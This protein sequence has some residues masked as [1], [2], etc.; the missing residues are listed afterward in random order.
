MDKFTSSLQDAFSRAHTA[1]V[2][3]N[4]AALSEP[5]L[6]WALAAP[7][8][9]SGRLLAAAG[10]DCAMLTQRMEALFGQLPKLGAAAQELAPDEGLRQLLQVAGRAASER[11]DGYLS[12]EMV[13]LAALRGS[14]EVAAAL[15][16]AGLGEDAL[17]R[18]LAT[19]RGGRPVADPEAEEQRQALERYTVDLTARARSG[20]LDPVIGRDEEIRRTIQVLQR[21]TKN[22]PVLIGEAGVGK[23]AIAEGLAQRMVDDEVPTGLRGR[24]LLALDLGALL[25]GAKYRGDFEERLRAVLQELKRERGGVVLFIDE[26][27]TMVG[28]GRAEGAID[29]GNMLKPALARGEL[30]CIGAT[31]LDEYREHLEKDA[32]LERRFQKI[33]VQEPGEE[34]AVAIMRGLK[35]RYEV[36][37][38]ITISDEA[39]LASVRFSQRY[40]SD[41]KLPDKAIDLVDE[42]ASCLRV[43]IDSRPDPLDRLQRRLEQLKMEREAVGSDEREQG[44]EALRGLD[45]QIAALERESGAL[46]EEWQREVESLRESQRLRTAIDRARVDFDAARRC[47]DLSEMARLQHGVIPELEG[48]LRIG[49]DEGEQPRRRL[50]ST[51]V[52]EEDI[53]AVVS[54]WTGIPVTRMLRG[55]REK[56]LQMEESLRRRVIGQE[57]ALGAVADAVRRARAGLSEAGRPNGSFF[58][59]GPTGVGKTE[60]CRALAEFLFDSD[61][62]MLR[63]D[64]SEYMEKHSVSRLIGAPPGY[65]GYE[66][67]GALTEAVRRRPY[68]VVLFD[69]IEKAHPEVANILLQL[70]DDGRLTDGHGRTVDFRHTVIVMTSNIGT[71]AELDDGNGDVPTVLL[72]GEPPPAAGDGR[73]NAALMAELRGYFR[74]ELLNRIDEI[75]IFQPLRR[76]HLEGII[77]RQLGLLSERLAVRGLSLELSAAARAQLLEQGYDPAFGARPLQR[78]LRRELERLLARRLLADELPAGTQ[79]QV[80]WRD[81]AFHVDSSSA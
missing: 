3:R 67:G 16:A 60:L 1:A 8:T 45:E 43:E 38:G 10:A 32:A 77:D 59:L 58:F 35:E 28:A 70:L 26:L 80:D 31:T 14:G 46:E 40:I 57:A 30:R 37:H 79:L 49:E 34:D 68:A 56:L 64:M 42:A 23:T 19:A 27:H 5:H 66:E 48:K 6:L 17:E 54:R 53:A 71:G 78:V 47:G 29:A 20:E 76:E 63:I 25:A 21:R 33:L 75:V 65:I 69:E 4:H 36:H 44:G 39:L 52:T 7:Q 18:A 12:G 62:A 51:R 24:R 61:S 81:G 50:L 41:R 15:A 2:E 72:D 74:P 13:W 11:G 73:E 9:P 22:N 55:E